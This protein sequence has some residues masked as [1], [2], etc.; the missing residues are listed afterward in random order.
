VRQRGDA[1]CQA[2]PREPVVLQSVPQREAASVTSYKMGPLK[3]QPLISTPFRKTGEWILK[4]A[5][6]LVVS[7]R[8]LCYKVGNFSR[9]IAGIWGWGRHGLQEAAVLPGSGLVNVRDPSHM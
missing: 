5:L 8:F 4:R 6:F 9:K 7:G 2:W 3:A 1:W